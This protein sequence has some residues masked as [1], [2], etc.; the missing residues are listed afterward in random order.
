MHCSIAIIA[1]L[2]SF[3]TACLHD[4]L[5][6]EHLSLPSPP[7][8]IEIRN[9]ARPQSNRVALKNVRVFDGYKIHKPSTLYIDGE[10]IVHGPLKHLD[11]TFDGQGRILI[12]GL[13]DAHTHPLSLKDLHSFSANGVTT[14]LSMSCF[15]EPLCQSLRNQVGLT[16]FYHAVR[17]AAGTNST[18][19]GPLLGLPPGYPI[20]S[21]AD[22]APYVR[23]AI[24]NGT[25]Y[26][27]IV[28]E[29]G[30]IDQES[31]N[32]VVAAAHAAGQQVNTHAVD[33]A[34]YDR[35][36][37]SKTDV[38][39]HSC[40]DAPL[41]PSMVSTILRQKQVV[42]ATISI[43]RKKD[44]L[45]P[46]L[47]V[48]VPANFFF[49]LAV[50]NTRLL[51][52]AGVTVLAGTDSNDVSPVFSV[53]FGSSLHDELEFLVGAGMTPAEALRAATV[54]L[55]KVHNLHDRGVIKPGKRADL[56]LLNGNP[57]MDIKA[58]RRVVGVW[59]GGLKYEGNDGKD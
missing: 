49:D 27:K 5:P 19:L 35:A 12:P 17:A 43:A 25:D 10:H 45:A 56:V 29:T 2:I 32:A 40:M 28:S 51:H 41:T 58:T 47:N 21:P 59:V 4:L 31:H 8:K 44:E 13:I 53:P 39:Q 52:Q 9:V 36:I 34:G 23:E 14:A 7:A 1:S 20:T 18:G 57:I 50:N 48:T 46:L 38:I 15:P 3:S 6:R 24:K 37:R 33:F 11:S 22:A 26:I 55:A 16:S 54:T 42:T 30:G